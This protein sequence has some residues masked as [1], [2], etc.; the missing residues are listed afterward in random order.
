MN[1]NLRP[2]IEQESVEDLIKQL[3]DTRFSNEQTRKDFISIIAK[4]AS[5]PDKTAR[6]VIKKIGDY[7]TDLGTEILNNSSSSVENPEE[8]DS[9]TIDMDKGAGVED[10]FDETIDEYNQRRRD[11]VEQS[12]KMQKYTRRFI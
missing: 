8:N 10:E 9:Y 11:E 7:M 2:M 1:K 3:R 6:S 12:R 4:L 5:A